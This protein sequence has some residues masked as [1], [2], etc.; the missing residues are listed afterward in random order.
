MNLPDKITLVRVALAPVFLILFY[1]ANNTENFVLKNF[2]IILLWVFFVIMELSDL[3]DGMAARR[4]K[5][6]SDLGKLFD[7]FADSFSR[8]TYFFCFLLAGIMNFWMFIIILYRDLI[9]SFLRQYLS[10]RNLVMGA[11]WSGKI[12]AWIYAAGGIC[13]IF[14]FSVKKLL[15]FVEQHVIINIV[16][17]SVFGMCTVIALVSL[18]DY[19]IFFVKNA[20]KVK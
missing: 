15:I 17:Q 18:L 14:Y 11:K 9:V 16:S 12:K 2:I 8:I 1:I 5:Q 3:F 4:L 6:T 19:L 20:K 10:T 13:G 7:P